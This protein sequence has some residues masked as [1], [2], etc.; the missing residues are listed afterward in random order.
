[1]STFLPSKPFIISLVVV[2]A[3]TIGVFLFISHQKDVS[4]DYK[5][6]LS[7]GQKI[8]LQDIIDR[9]TDGDG[10]KDWEESLWGTDPTKADTN[11]DGVSDKEEVDNKRKELK[12]KNG[13]DETTA[14][15]NE[16]STLARELFATVASLQASGNLTTDSVT[17]LTGNVRDSVVSQARL[18]DIYTAADIKVTPGNDKATI[19]KYYTAITKI[20][21]NYAYRTWG[22]E[23]AI[24][25]KAMN[26]NNPKLLEDLDD[27]ADVYKSFSKEIQVI[28]VPPELVPLHLAIINSAINIG[29]S[30]QNMEQVFDNS[31]IGMV[32]VYQ[33]SFYN[34][35]LVKN[36]ESL[37]LYFQN[38]GILTE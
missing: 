18:P 6:T 1:M 24:A 7:E 11:G 20:T 22:D 30:L 36:I 38:N 17:A 8:A 3:L 2:V 27:R 23:L 5:N 16:T 10:V 29:I 28:P 34:E 35:A 25:N 37:R 12:L 32:G 26:E 21:D 13:T 33:Y 14:T 4:L 19:S 9:D 15:T 31:L